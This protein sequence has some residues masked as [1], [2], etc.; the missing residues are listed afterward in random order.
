MRL[1][2]DLIA[3]L[4][5]SDLAAEP[6]WPSAMVAGAAHYSDADCREL[7]SPIDG[8]VLGRYAPATV[9]IVQL[10]VEAAHGAF[11]KWRMVPA[12]LRG[13]LVRRIGEL[14]RQ[15]HTAL[16][17]LITLEV[18]KTHAEAEAEV[19]VWID[20]CDYA[21]GLSRQLHG[22]T[23]PSERPQH[24]LMEQWHPLGAVGLITP[25][26]FP[27]GIWA[28]NAMI[29]LV[30]GDTLVWKPSEKAPLCA[31]A[32]QRLVESVVEDMDGRMP[33][34]VCQ[35][36]LGGPETGEIVARHPLLPLIAATGSTA[37]GRRVAAD[38]AAR[39]GRSALLLSGN[40]AIIVAESA[41]LDLAV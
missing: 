13:E 35:L 36:L 1:P 31:I 20:S 39:L 30:C 3:D 12:P 25:F 29:A 34:H 27:L 15:R 18:G 33:A 26:N 19:Q 10:A 16:A 7:R 6:V 17:H 23:L 28:W 41:D 2:A 14:V 4:H 37:M 5:L 9:G 22:A 21:L 11:L 38:V 8:T 32:V 40:N 24:R